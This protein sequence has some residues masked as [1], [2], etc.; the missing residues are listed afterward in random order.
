[1]EMNFYSDDEFARE[2]NN[3]IGNVKYM[4]KRLREIGKIGVRQQLS[5]DFIELFNT[6][7]QIK[8][9]NHTTWEHAIDITF[10]EKYSESK[11]INPNSKDG[12]SDDILEEILAT[13]K[14]IEQKL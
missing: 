4:K 12:Q 9:E 10:E 8:D 1:M 3:S 5:S 7:K 13:L 6:I 14:R 11:V 2:V